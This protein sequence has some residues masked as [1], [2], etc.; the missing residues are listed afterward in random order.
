MK[1]EVTPREFFEY[2]TG[3]LLMIGK[4]EDMTP[5]MQKHALQV[6]MHS[7]AVLNE[8]PDDLFPDLIKDGEAV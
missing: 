6:M 7:Q 4:H 2:V 8:L 5:K 1:N 3:A